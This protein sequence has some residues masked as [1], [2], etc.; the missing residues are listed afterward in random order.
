MFSAPWW[1]LGMLFVAGFVAGYALLLRR[2][3]RDTM[4]FTNLALLERFA[5]RA[6]GRLRHLPVTL[7]ITALAV[8]VVALA[9][10]Q[11]DA[12]VPRH[13]AVVMLVIDV[14]LSMQ[15][16]DVAPSRL[17]AA[18]TAAKQFA[19][20]LPP[21]INLGLESFAGTAA[22]L[23][24]PT[25]DRDA[26]KR[27]IDGLRLAESTAT[28]EAIFAALQSVQAFGG[29]FTG[30]SDGPLP[31]HVVLMSD[32]GQTVPGGPDA[33]DQPRGGFTAARAAAAAKVPVSTIS[34]GTSYGTVELGAGQPP[35]PVPVDDDA[36][37]Q[38]AQLSGGQAFT[39]RT[40]DQLQQ[41][42]ATLND[43]IGYEIRRV[44]QTRPWLTGGTFLLIA[45]VGAGLG[46]GR[47][48]P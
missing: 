28:G 10:P 29:G 33:E 34:F 20:E 2:R 24:A 30:T 39:A 8:L 35:L 21:G 17:A 25:V 32:G 43:Q 9:G 40:E 11:A 37:R 1:L 27:G 6:P 18:Q 19:D 23:I 41:V 36:L 4:V 48:I 42:Y 14:S 7:L 46:L 47:R 3:R 44:D 13:R 12:K 16:V 22:V 26:V 5:P 31:A 38:I 15:A 45:G